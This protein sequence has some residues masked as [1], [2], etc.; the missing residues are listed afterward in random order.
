MTHG[1][2]GYEPSGS[3]V[4]GSGT[5]GD[6]SAWYGSPPSPRSSP[7]SYGPG[8][9]SYGPRPAGADPQP[10][11][12]RGA[13]AKAAAVVMLAWVA[14]LWVLEY[15]D[16]ATGHALDTYGITPRRIGELRD[17]VPAAFIHFGFGHLI[18]NTVPLLVLGFLAAL[19]GV[20]RFL[21]VVMVIILV[22]GLGVWLVAPPHSLTAGASGVIFGLFGYLLAR[23]FVDRRPAWILLGLIV[24]VLYGSILWG[25]LP[26]ASGISWQGHL[27]GL[28]GG[29]AA[30]FLFREHRREHPAGL[31]R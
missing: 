3:R 14:L 6:G 1:L 23:G 17:I 22:S 4:P 2:S 8:W 31:T 11:R 15:V 12:R 24:A 20:Q 5:R 18:A 29:V 19:A 26:T 30:A 13:R 28:L 21:G 27:F 25:A 9:G 7:Y 16:T 10:P